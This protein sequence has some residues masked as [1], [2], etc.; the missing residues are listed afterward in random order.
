MTINWS[1]TKNGKKSIRELRDYNLI[2][3]SH[4]DEIE[5]SK[6][7]NSRCHM[8][9][10]I[11]GK[12]TLRGIETKIDKTE[13]S[14]GDKTFTMRFVYCSNCTILLLSERIKELRKLRKL[15]KNRERTREV[16]YKKQSDLQLKDDLLNKLDNKDEEFKDDS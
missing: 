10:K 6:S 5:R 13:L 2:G 14:K 3:F 9:K 8:C 1:K 4:I 15:M 11:I 7:N 12:N 16:A